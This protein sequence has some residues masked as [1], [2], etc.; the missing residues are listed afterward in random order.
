MDSKEQNNTL[1]AIHHLYLGVNDLLYCQQETLKSLK[2]HQG[3]VG[4][5]ELS[6]YLKQSSNA[7]KKVAQN[8][9]HLGIQV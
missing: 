2:A 6:G 9:K 3:L 4:G 1:S 7:L 5:A 8:L